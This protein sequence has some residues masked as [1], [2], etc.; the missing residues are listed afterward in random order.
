MNLDLKTVTPYIVMIIGFAASWGMWKSRLEA[1]ETK[2]DTITQ[3][4]LDIA[5]I[6]ERMIQLDNRTQF[7]EEYL[8]KLY[9]GE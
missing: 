9:D 3:M 5:V 7:I 1:V 2:V 6:K 4:Q 8:I